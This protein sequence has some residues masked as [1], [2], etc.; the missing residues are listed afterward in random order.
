[1]NS[2]T[3]NT[4]FIALRYRDYR[5]WWV[6]QLISQA[7][8]AMQT[9]AVNW[10][11]S[12]LTGFNPMALGLVGLSRFVPIVIFSLIGGAVADARNRR[13]VLIVTQSILALL[14]AVLGL[15]TS[16]GLS[17]VWPIYAI[18]ALSAATLA[19]N[20]PARQALI[21]ALLPREHLANALSLNSIMGQMATIGGAL[22]GGLLIGAHDTAIVYW[23]NAVS[24]FAVIVA[25]VAMRPA[26]QEIRRKASIGSVREGLRFV[27][28]QPIIF[29][30]MLLDF[31][32]TFF[33]SANQLLP[34]FAA[35]ILNV[36]APGLGALT[37]ATSVGSFMAGGVMGFVSRVKKPGRV[38]LYA[39]AVYGLA[40]V[41]FGLSR[42]FVV[43]LFMLG[44]TGAADTISTILRGTIRQLVTPDEMRGRMTSVNMVFFMGGPQLGEA[45][46]GLAAAWLGAP[47]SVITGGLGCLIAVVLTAWKAPTLRRFDEDDLKRAGERLTNESLVVA[48]GK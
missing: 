4:P 31:I 30:T 11:I 3:K 13:K 47:L 21:P 23:L 14:A 25:L 19:F 12:Q 26:Q 22:L 43:S 15:L 27:F 5:L 20:N 46:A 39:V 1:M 10:Q 42:D 40:T 8:S 45:E 18:S 41:L 16:A 17:V 28:T 32:A 9:L 44:L 7:G 2:R 34:I 33:S 38:I 24:F 48:A 29:S 6:G 36:G 37:A 35:Q